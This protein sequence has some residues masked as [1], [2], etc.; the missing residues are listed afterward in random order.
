MCKSQLV[1]ECVNLQEKFASGGSGIT[2]PRRAGIK[3]KNQ[4][5]PKMLMLGGAVRRSRLP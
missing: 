2:E 4:A 5:Y 1:S 3:S